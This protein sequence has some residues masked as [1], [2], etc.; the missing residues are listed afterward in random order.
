MKRRLFWKILLA[1]WLTFFL[2]VQGIW[3]MFMFLRSEPS[4]FARSMAKMSVAAASAAIGTGGESGY[5]A[6]VAG[7]LKEQKS[8]IELRP[9]TAPAGTRPVMAQA[10]ASSPD[11]TRY[12][13]TY[14]RQTQSRGLFNIPREVV[15]AGAAGGLLFSALLAWYLTQ[16]V[17]RMRAGFRRL[18]Q[19]DF[20]TR[21][22]LR[23]GAAATRSPTSP[24]IST[25]W[26]RS[27]RNWW[28]PVTAC[29]PTFPMSCA[30]PWRA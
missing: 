20:T 6:E 2:I 28:R 25:R 12:R 8:Q 26:R 30:R 24:M 13:I 3:L 1:F 9:A 7:W 5:R 27:F 11:G 23:W 17:E 21:L 14:Y 22:A 10:T 4:D 15:I 29:W 16:P 19:G 18:A